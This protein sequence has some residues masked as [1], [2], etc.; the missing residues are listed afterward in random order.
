MRLRRAATKLLSIKGLA[1][2]AAAALADA[3]ESAGTASDVARYLAIELEHTRG[4][5][6]REVLTRLAV[7]RQDRL[8]DAAGAYE[9]FEQA[10]LLDPSED[11]DR[12]RFMTLSLKLGTESE[13][14]RA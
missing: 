3:T 1:A 2:R 13:A 10:L 11:E 14:I 6:R 4:P 9:A 5:K 7:L 8:N 12:V